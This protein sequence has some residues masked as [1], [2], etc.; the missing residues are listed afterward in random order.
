MEQ[1]KDRLIEEKKKLHADRKRAQLFEGMM[2]HPG[3]QLYVALLNYHIGTRMEALIQPTPSLG[4]LAA[5][6]NKGAV[7]GLTLARDLPRGTVEAAKTSGPATD[8]E[9]DE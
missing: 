7:F 9:D 5:E 8:G 6:H 2:A 1:D 4:E 3:W